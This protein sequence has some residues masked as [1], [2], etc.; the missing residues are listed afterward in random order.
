[1]LDIER[2]LRAADGHI[3]IRPLAGDHVGIIVFDHGYGSSEFVRG[4]FLD[5]LERALH[6]IREGTHHPPSHEPGAPLRWH[7]FTHDESHRATLPGGE[8]RVVKHAGTC[9]L[10]HVRRDS[11][12][13]FGCGSKDELLEAVKSSYSKFE[14]HHRPLSIVHRG[15]RYDLKL[16]FNSDDLAAVTAGDG[17]RFSVRITGN[18][19]L[20]LDRLAEGERSCI[21]TFAHAFDGL[22]EF[23]WSDG[24]EPSPQQ[25]SPTP[26]A[27]GTVRPSAG[28]R[29]AGPLTPEVR[30]ATLAM[31]QYLAMLGGAGMCVRL[32]C[33]TAFERLADLG[34]RVQGRG[35]EL[36]KQLKLHSGVDLPGGMRVFRYAMATCRKLGL[37]VSDGTLDIFPFDDLHDPASEFARAVV[38]VF[39]KTAPIRP[40]NDVPSTAAP[41]TSASYASTGAPTVTQDPPA[42]PAAAPESPTTPSPPDAPKA[43]VEFYPPDTWPFQDDT[44]GSHEVEG[45][46]L[47][48][49][50]DACDPGAA[51]V[52]HVNWFGH[53]YH[54]P[55]GISFTLTPTGVDAIEDPPEPAGEEFF[56][57]LRRAFTRDPTG[58]S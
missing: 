12:C 25:S 33:R 10:V 46:N 20:H 49:S 18:D 4:P 14:A 27:L 47:T 1:M 21:K 53:K 54:V 6:V 3:E 43:S 40:D 41:P 23:L 39:G 29:P 13:V 22:P 8:L 31:F 35:E 44:V 36:R 51:P 48:G 9:F 30:A 32:W 15:R 26:P 19:T 7:H 17:T 24:I 56:E 45:A 55:D 28:S 57:N 5:C 34:I 38:A 58:D 50:M 42:E 16:T 11:C 37:L 52:D 2:N